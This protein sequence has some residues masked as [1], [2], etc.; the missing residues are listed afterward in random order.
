MVGLSH[1]FPEI[2]AF[3]TSTFSEA[4]FVPASTARAASVISQ[5]SSGNYWISGRERTLSKS[6]YQRHSAL[7]IQGIGDFLTCPSEGWVQLVRSDEPCSM[8]ELLEIAIG[9]LLIPLLAERGIFMLHASS[10]ATHHGVVAFVGD[11]GAG[12]STLAAFLAASLSLPNLVSDDQL[13]ISRSYDDIKQIDVLPDFPQLKIPPDRQPG[14]QLS[15]RLPLYALVVLEQSQHPQD[16]QLE[17]FDSAKMATTLIRHSVAT[18]LFT[19][20][21]LAKHLDFCSTSCAN[22]RGYV[23]RYPRKLYLLPRIRELLA[24][25]LWPIN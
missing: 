21:L 19:K 12:K 6:S 7:S 14:L 8:Q 9:P 2:S 4:R 1:S 3:S 25:R 13:P 11:S 5:Q 10:V 17:P 18:R 15:P 24:S 20:E 16:I 23:L 22:I